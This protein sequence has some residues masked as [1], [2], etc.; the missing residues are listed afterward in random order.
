MPFTWSTP[1]RCP[2]N[3]LYPAMYPSYTVLITMGAYPDAYLSV[4]PVRNSLLLQRLMMLYWTFIVSLCAAAHIWQSVALTLS[5]VNLVCHECAQ[6]MDAPPV[7]VKSPTHRRCLRSRIR[8]PLRCAIRL[9]YDSEDPI[10]LLQELAN[11]ECCAK[12]LFFLIRL[13]CVC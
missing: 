2:G 5:K 1:N 4:S 3:M 8:E 12:T 11:T 9:T 13:L 7:G 10:F 6:V